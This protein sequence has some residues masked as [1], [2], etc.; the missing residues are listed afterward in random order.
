M[1][2]VVPLPR[3]LVSKEGDMKESWRRWRQIWDSYETISRLK[4]QPHN[5]RLA[6]F[7]EEDALEIFNSLFGD[8][9]AT[10]ADMDFVLRTLETHFMG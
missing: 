8:A 9:E 10:H 3:P 6:T 1:R 7:I 5:L 2:N 4:E